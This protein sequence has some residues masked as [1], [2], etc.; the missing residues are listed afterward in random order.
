MAIGTEKEN[1]IKII[2][3]SPIEREKNKTDTQPKKSL[4]QTHNLVGPSMQKL[5]QTPAACSYGHRRYSQEDG[6]TDL[7][8]DAARP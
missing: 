7:S 2:K 5:L 8:R 6:E 4:D 1:K 3:S